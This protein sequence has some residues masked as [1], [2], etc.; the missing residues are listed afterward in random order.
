MKEFVVNINGIL[1]RQKLS[2]MSTKGINN[3]NSC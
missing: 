2:I 1:D 3:Q